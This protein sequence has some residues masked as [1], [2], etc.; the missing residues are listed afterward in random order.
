[1]K[2][3][4]RINYNDI[5]IIIQSMIRCHKF[6]LNL[7]QGRRHMSK[8]TP[9]KC[10]SVRTPNRRLTLIDF[11]LEDTQDWAVLEPGVTYH[12]LLTGS[13]I[14]CVTVASDVST[15]TIQNES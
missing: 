1:M 2:G 14:Q 3:L 9:S 8:K 11:K 13:S 6:H 4:K 10:S 12:L 7:S 15:V 5:I